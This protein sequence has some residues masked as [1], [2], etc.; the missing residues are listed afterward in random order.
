MREGLKVKQELSKY[1]VVR[2]S[3]AGP[4]KKKKRNLLV[5]N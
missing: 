3:S 2:L 5:G 4:G 1:Q